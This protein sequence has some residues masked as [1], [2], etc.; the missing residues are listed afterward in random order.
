MLVRQMVDHLLHTLDSEVLEEAT[1]VLRFFAPTPDSS[2]HCAK[3]ALI[4]LDQ[5]VRLRIATTV[6]LGFLF[7]DCTQL[8]HVVRAVANLMQ[9]VPLLLRMLAT[10]LGKVVRSCMAVCGGRRSTCTRSRGRR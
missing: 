8:C 10:V 5:R 4:R 6:S 9:T 2:E 1:L 7:V 3:A